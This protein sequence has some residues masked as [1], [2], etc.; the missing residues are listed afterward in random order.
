M[1][2]DEKML[3]WEQIRFLRTS[4]RYTQED[5]GELLGMTQSA[6]SLKETEHP[7]ELVEP[8]LARRALEA[9]IQPPRKREKARAQGIVT[10]DDVESAASTQRWTILFARGSLPRGAKL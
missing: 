1:S 10:P 5:F 8:H 9:P 7:G 2:R 4:K 6:L 3:T